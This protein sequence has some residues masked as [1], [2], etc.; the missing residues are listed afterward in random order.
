MRRWPTKWPCSDQRMRCRVVSGVQ[1]T[2][3]SRSA[4][5]STGSGDGIPPVTGICLAK[6]GEGEEGICNVVSGNSTGL[7]S[8]DESDGVSGDASGDILDGV[9]RARSNSCVPFVTPCILY[10]HPTPVSFGSTPGSAFSVIE[11]RLFRSEHGS[12]SVCVGDFCDFSV[13][14]V[15]GR[16]RE[17]KRVGEGGARFGCFRN[18]RDKKRESLPPF[19]GNETR[20]LLNLS[21]PSI[22]PSICPSIGFSSKSNSLPPDTVGCLAWS[23]V[24]CADDIGKGVEVL[25]VD[26][27]LPSSISQRC[28]ASH[29]TR[30]HI[31]GPH[32]TG[33]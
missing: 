5:V 27:S 3:C 32:V 21:S 24:A 13:I 19:L 11:R 7:M 31:N 8:G 18:I 6:C 14:N 9:Q 25:H 33:D 28:L 20:V 30:S 15:D 12:R 26:I 10:P 2:R 16:E 1:A 17:G 4:G 29:A 23:A 22:C